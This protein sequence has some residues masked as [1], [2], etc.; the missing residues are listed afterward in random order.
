MPPQLKTCDRCQQAKPATEAYFDPHLRQPDRLKTYCRACS[1]AVTAERRQRKA[2][3]A[4]EWARNN[5]EKVRESVRRTYEKNRSQRLAYMLRWR[6]ENK[7]RIAEYQ[8][9]YVARRR[10]E[11]K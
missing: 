11:T 5:P 8:R 6:K 1:P 4:R 2:E 3:N 7:E 9:E 10:Q